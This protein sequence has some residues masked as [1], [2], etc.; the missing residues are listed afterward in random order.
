M[1]V[2]CGACA[3]IKRDAA[4]YARHHQGVLPRVRTAIGI[5]FTIL[6]L[7][8]RVLA[9]PVNTSLIVRG[10]SVMHSTTAVGACFVESQVA[11]LLANMQGRRQILW[12]CR[13]LKL[14]PDLNDVEALISSV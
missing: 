12:H 14:S 4:R 5:I 6:P 8:L 2:S 10:I 3:I 9:F 7:H 1:Q 11:K 13:Q